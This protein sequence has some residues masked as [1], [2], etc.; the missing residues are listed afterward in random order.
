MEEG[1]PISD[2]DAIR[3]FYDSEVPAAIERL[4]QQPSFHTALKFVF[5]DTPLDRLDQAISEIKTIE[6]FQNFIASAAVKK[7]IE[8][9]THGVNIGGLENLDAKKAFL[10]ISNHR[11]IVLDSAFLNYELYQ[12]NFPT[13]RIAI[14]SNLLQRPWIEDLVKLNK[15]FIVHR[16]VH[17]RLAYEYSMRL[18]GF[19]SHSIIDENISVWIAQKEGRAK[20][21]NDKTHAGLVKMFGMSARGEDIPAFYNSL[22]IAPVS[23]SYEIE[24]CGGLKA[25]EMFIRA[26]QGNYKKEDGED[27]RSMQIGITGDKGK[28]HFQFSAPLEKNKISSCFEGYSKNDSIK[29]LAIKI[30]ELIIGSY[31]LFPNNYVAYYLKTGDNRFNDLFTSE[32]LNIFNDLMDFEL[33]GFEFGF[34]ELKPYFID[35]YANPIINKINIGAI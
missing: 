17:S 6:D 24:P 27:L 2:F 11:D 5:P 14:G 23:I 26:S 32:Q 20:N 33:A 7:I 25:R 12:N 8:V 19:I 29:N 10:F 35:I 30:D 31:H 16:D 15:N 34:E 4:R 1:K 13:T 3:P 9:S 22:N 28:V 18:S 21:G